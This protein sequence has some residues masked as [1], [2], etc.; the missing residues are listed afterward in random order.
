MATTK[1]RP[2]PSQIVT[3]KEAADF[4]RLSTNTLAKKRVEGTGPAFIKIFGRVM[5]ERSELEAFVAKGRRQSTS[6]QT[7]QDART[8]QSRVSAIFGEDKKDS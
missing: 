7:V 1:P 8:L 4:L 2:I 3:A 5:Y 6:D